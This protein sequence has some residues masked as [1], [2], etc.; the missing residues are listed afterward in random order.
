MKN[1]NKLN[2]FDEYFVYGVNGARAVFNS[3][4]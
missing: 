1:K 3:D 2:E 4:K